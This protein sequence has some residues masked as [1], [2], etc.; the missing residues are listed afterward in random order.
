MLRELRDALAAEDGRPVRVE[1]LARRLAMEPAAVAAMLD[2]ARR[3][4][5]VPVSGSCSTDS[6]AA[7]ARGCR[8]C[9]LASPAQRA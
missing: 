4:G 8:H 6:C 3:R 2:H 9:P 1:V 7:H 5:L